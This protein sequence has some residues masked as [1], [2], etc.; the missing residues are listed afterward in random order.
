MKKFRILPSENEQI[1]TSSANSGNMSIAFRDNIFSSKMQE[2]PKI[3]VAPRER[4][5]ENMMRGVELPA[6]ELEVD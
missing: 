4:G 1:A 3:V 6:E 2:N 5:Y